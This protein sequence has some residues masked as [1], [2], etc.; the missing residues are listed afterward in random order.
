VNSGSLI[1]KEPRANSFL[2]VSILYFLSQ[3]PI[4]LTRNGIWWDD[5]TL[6]NVESQVIEDMFKSAGMFPPIDAPLHIFLMSIGPWTYKL[7]TFILFYFCSIAAYVLMERYLN[8]NIYQLRTAAVLFA[9]LPLN[10]ARVAAIDFPYTLSL[11]L[12]L[13]A[14]IIYPKLKLFSLSLFF[15]SFLMQSLLTFILLVLIS[16]FT[17][18][19]K[20][21]LAK[22]RIFVY[23]NS[24]LII[25]PGL[26]WLIKN[27][28]FKPTGIYLDYNQNIAIENL[29][30]AAKEM[31]IDAFFHFRIPVGLTLIYILIVY[32]LF[33]KF[34]SSDTDLNFKSHYFVGIFALFLGVFPYLLIGKAPSFY[35][36]G[37]R[38]Q[39]LMPI[40]IALIITSILSLN[41]KFSSPVIICLIAVSLSCFNASYIHLAKDWS[42]QIQI[43]SQLRN[44]PLMDSCSEIEV[45]DL[46]QDLN[47][48]GRTYRFY[49]WNGISKM[50]TGNESHFIYNKSEAPA[51]KSGDYNN[52]FNDQFSA[53]EFSQTLKNVKCDMYISRDIQDSNKVRILISRLD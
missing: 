43:I 48:F 3:L 4:F 22:Y 52:Y 9:V 28:F 24:G 49:E 44:L 6:F 42:K 1:W 23:K 19:R 32:M 37:S 53:G 5:W 36:W 30:P 46:T 27:I 38:H 10:Y 51:F 16:E 34:N 18:W 45:Q 2:F 8:F 31:L 12:F 14:W 13:L 35:D 20:D 17:T 21:N 50:A 47:A 39:I 25:I 41:R 33:R 40:G 15:V 26:Y 7:L 29:L 11:T